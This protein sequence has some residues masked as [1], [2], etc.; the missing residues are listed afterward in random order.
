MI[1]PTQPTQRTDLFVFWYNPN[2]YTVTFKKGHRVYAAKRPQTGPFKAGG[3]I[4]NNPFIASP[5]RRLSR[6]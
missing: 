2:F 3:Y 1:Q 4:Y 6:V 5:V